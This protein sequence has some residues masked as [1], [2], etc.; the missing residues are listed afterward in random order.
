[1]KATVSILLACVCAAG[2]AFASSCVDEVVAPIR[3]AKGAVCWSYDGKATHFTGRFSRGQRV[4]IEMR[5]QYSRVTDPVSEKTET[6]WAP[7]IPQIEGPNRFFVSAD[8]PAEGAAAGRLEVILPE[9]GE[10]KFGFSPC[11]MWHQNG[12]VSICTTGSA[13]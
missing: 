1:M 3:F 12:H 7:R 13:E 6:V 11:V 2:P 9:T 10:Y 4:T 8:P 5:G